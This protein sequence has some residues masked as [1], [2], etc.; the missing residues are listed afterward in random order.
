MNIFARAA[1][2]L[3]VAIFC[4]TFSGK[5]EAQITPRQKIQQCFQSGAFDQ[6]LM[7]MCTGLNV[8][9]STFA[10]CMSGGPCFGEISGPFVP[11]S[12]GAPFCGVMGTPYCPVPRSCGS[13]FSIPCPF[14]IPPGY[15]PP[16]FITAPACGS[17]GFPPC[18]TPVPCGVYGGLPCPTS[19]V[20]PGMWHG[21][22]DTF[23]PGTEQQN[24]YV[25]VPDNP[26]AAQQQSGITFAEPAVPDV[27]KLMQCR[28]ST[29]NEQAFWTCVAEQ[30]LPGKYKL[31]AS[32][33]ASNSD[34]PVSA[35]A[36]S[37]GDSNLQQSVDRF[38]QVK[39]CLE[40]HG[41]DSPALAGCL[42]TPYLGAK[43]KLYAGCLVNNY[44]PANG[45][46]Y[47]GAALCALGPQLTPEQQVALDCAVTT[48]GNPKLW[49][50][51]TGG[52]LAATELD[53][54]WSNGIATPGGAL[55]RTMPFDSGQT[56]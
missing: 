29:S 50:V 9:Q 37:S 46:N 51:C 6:R 17:Y 20:V 5:A 23:A 54:C 49:A 40:V 55:D 38:K 19:P 24:I 48:G 41:Q 31:L 27:S 3:V 32:C 15:P 4:F 22:L 39:S 2:V 28:S 30:A 44:N 8:S 45:L 7:Q 43:E 21:A 14:F 13:A 34:D 12:M 36:C 16:P 11:P 53:K 18:A 35:Y 52:R 1:L 33:V 26:E 42:A 47:T 10:S 25:A 56:S